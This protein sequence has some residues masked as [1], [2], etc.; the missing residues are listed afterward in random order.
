M[1]S[2][3]IRSV[4][5]MS[6]VLPHQSGSWQRLE[7]V[8]RDL[9]RQY[10]YREIRPPV[11]EHSGLFKRSIGEHTDIVEKEMYTFTDRGEDSLSLRPEATASCMR[12]GIQHGLFHNN[13][14]R[15]WYM[16]PMFRRERPQKGR[17]R[18][19]HQFG[20]E[21][22]G[23]PGP[24]SDAEVLLLGA[25]LFRALGVDGLR[26]E[27]NT[28]GGVRARAAYRDALVGYF[29]SRSEALD[30]DSKRRLH[31][32]PLRILD[33]K[34]P[35][36][37]ELLGD[38]PLILDYL[39]APDRAFFRALRGLLDAAG[40]GYTVNP[41]LV[42]GLD[43]YTST[44]FEWS[45]GG[46]AQNAVCAGGRYDHLV[47]AL[48][49]KPT[50]AVGFALGLERLMARLAGDAGDDAAASQDA[51]VAYLAVLDEAAGGAALAAAEQ[52]RDAGIA[53]Q[54]HCGGGAVKSQLRHAD[55]SGARYALILGA[56]EFASGVLGL[57]SLRT[58]APQESLPMDEIIARLRAACPPPDHPAPNNE[59]G[60]TL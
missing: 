17:Y 29:Q 43:Y 38:A 20:I 11:V 41:R 36:M 50:P 59:T 46:G 45:A 55:R 34:N 49:G 47:E 28:L 18:Q 21:A 1:R 23:W 32:N 56:G 4:R 6:D 10:G 51:P 42:R 53:V 39:E 40:V 24:D 58:D 14:E 54:L 16:G 3:A 37:Q 9:S 25:R 57:K 19:F 22:V 27:I 8:L 13:R 5:G 30:E 35:A 52:L 12:A 2:E 31:D 7:Q 26:L 48:G 44:V 15:M 33:S 60:R